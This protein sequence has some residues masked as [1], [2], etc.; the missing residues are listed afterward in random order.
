M[1]IEG[2]DSDKSYRREDIYSNVVRAGKR[3]Y[4]F[5][6]RTTRAGD[7]YLTI[8]ES[9]KKF[10]EDGTF[11]YQ[12]HKLFLY[13]EDFEKFANALTDSI[14]KVIEVQNDISIGR[15]DTKFADVSF[16]DLGKDDNDTIKEEESSSGEE[17]SS[18]EE[19][20]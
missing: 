2:K 12:K 9:R 11:F 4:F 17:E 3:T 15:I 5:D 13:K 1:T 10:N 20:K 18:S 19:D 6:V 8:T 16:D 14:K 7:Y